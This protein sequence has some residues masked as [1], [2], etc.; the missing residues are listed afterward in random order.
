MI[1]PI[2]TAFENLFNRG[3]R[4][5][6]QEIHE[7][8]SGALGK[9]MRFT[10]LSPPPGGDGAPHVIYLLHGLGNDHR[11]LD[12][13]GLSD[14]L[15]GAMERGDAPR[16]HIVTPNGERGFYINWRDGTRPYEDHILKEVLPRAEELIGAAVPRERRHLLGVSMGGLGAMQMG[17]RHPELFS[18]IAAL[19]APILDEVQAVAHVRDSSFLRWFVDFERIFGDLEDGEFLRTHNPY[20]ILRR[21]DPGEACQRL[22][23]ATGDREKPFFLDTSRAFH[24]F[25]AKRGVDHHWEEY[26]GGHGWRFWSPVIER[27]LSWAVG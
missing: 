16:A 9:P 8:R 14:S 3:Y 15:H 11:V 13:F 21:R 27:A 25:L 6:R 20:A 12:K 26:R 23:L 22:F 17:L 24:L 1:H 5:A 7:I 4:S 10:L 18:S 19:S 2:L